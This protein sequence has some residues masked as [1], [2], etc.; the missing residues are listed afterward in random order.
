MIFLVNGRIK[1][2]TINTKSLKDAAKSEIEKRDYD[3]TGNLIRK[4]A[5]G[6][7]AQEYYYKENKD[8]VLTKS[9]LVVKPE[10]DGN[11]FFSGTQIKNGVLIVD[12]EFLRGGCTHIYRYQNGGFYLIGARN[13]TGDPSYMESFEYNLSTG[14]YVYDYSNDDDDTKSVKKQGTHKL[15]PLPKLETFELFS[16]EVDGKRF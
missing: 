2:I 12:H 14:K 15:N 1:T 16:I 4:T 5:S 8:A 7:Y 13:N 9:N 3:K 10:D 11:T 6:K